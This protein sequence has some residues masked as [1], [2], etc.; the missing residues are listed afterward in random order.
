MT[1]EVSGLTAAELVSLLPDY[2][3]SPLQIWAC[4]RLGLDG[5]EDW[6][7]GRVLSRQFARY[8]LGSVLVALESLPDVAER[9]PPDGDRRP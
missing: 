8:D 9:A 1:A 7:E 6:W 5:E 3:D 4:E 2:L